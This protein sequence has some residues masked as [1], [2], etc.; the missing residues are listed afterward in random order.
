MVKLNIIKESKHP[1]EQQSNLIMI[2]MPDKSLRLYLD[3]KK[4]NKYIECDMCLIPILD[5]MKPIFS[6]RNTNSLLDLKKNFYHCE[7][8]ME[9][10]KFCT[11][12]SSG[13]AKG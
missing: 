6:N 1:R 4:I 10:V 3:P 5:D 13:V 9:S 12:S 7:L 2:E 11:F 8:D